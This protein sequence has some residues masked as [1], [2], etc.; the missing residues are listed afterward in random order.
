VTT[1]YYKNYGNYWKKILDKNNI[2]GYNLSVIGKYWKIKE[3]EKWKNKSM[4]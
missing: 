2:R 3:L 1:K 4:S